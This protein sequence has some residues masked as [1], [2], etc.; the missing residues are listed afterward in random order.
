MTREEFIT[1]YLERSKLSSDC[2]TE[3]GF[4]AGGHIRYAV[5][6]DCR[7][8]TCEGWAMISDEGMEHHLKFNAPNRKSL[9]E[10]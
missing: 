7:D 8:D 6:C 9:K 4:S 10:V 1:R 5:P 3:N 2:R